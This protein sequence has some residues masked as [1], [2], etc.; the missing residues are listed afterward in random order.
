V[1]YGDFGTARLRN[2]RQNVGQVGCEADFSPWGEGGTMGLRRWDRLGGED[3]ILQG[4]IDNEG[5]YFFAEAR[6]VKE[7]ELGRDY[8]TG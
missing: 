6:E 7:P 3:F 8:C 1:G 4:A 2:W 5:N